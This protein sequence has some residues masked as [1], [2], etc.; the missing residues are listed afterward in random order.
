M[1][2]LNGV[3][4]FFMLPWMFRVLNSNHVV[5]R[6]YDIL[7]SLRKNLNGKVRSKKLGIVNIFSKFE[8]EEIV[9]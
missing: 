7:P 9:K 2:G 6:S 4:K 8:E 5:A 1:E 3:M